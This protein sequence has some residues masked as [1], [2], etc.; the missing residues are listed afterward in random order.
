MGDKGMPQSK[1]EQFARLLVSIG[2]AVARLERERVCCGE[3][4][5]QQF[6]TLRRIERDGTDTVGAISGALGID[7]SPASRNV[8]ILV[9]DGYLRR[10]RDQE[11][12]RSFRLVLT[13]KGQAAL[14]DLAC[15]ERDVFTAVFDRMPP[16]D[17]SASLAVLTSLERALGD[18]EP[19]CCPPPE[20]VRAGRGRARSS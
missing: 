14:A 1:R 4:T 17:R 18:D 16:A 6:D 11:D 13:A 9:R 5:F 7:D 15:D 20:P 19:E 3:L 2:H 12:G 8:G 10:T